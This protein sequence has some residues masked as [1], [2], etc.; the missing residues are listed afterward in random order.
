MMNAKGMLT[1]LPGGEEGGKIG[2]DVRAIDGG[3]E[4]AERT[5]KWTNS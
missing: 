3:K 4:G 5:G 1:G 2:T